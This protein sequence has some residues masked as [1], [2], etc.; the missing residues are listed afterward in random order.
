MEKLQKLVFRFV[1]WAVKLVYP[2]TTV[3]GLE[4]L[5][6][7]PAIIVANHAQMHGPIVG[8]LYFPGPRATWCAGEMMVLKEVP[9]YAYQDF[10]SNK[11]KYIRWFFKLASYVI[12]PLCV[13]VF[14]HAL[15]IPVWRGQKVIRTFRASVEGLKE[16][17]N[18]IIF[19]EHSQPHDHI[20]CDFQEG[21]VDLARMYYKQTG[22][23]VCFV[24]MYLA[25]ALHGAYLGEPVRYRAE[26]NI[27]DERRRICDQLMERISA[28]A[29]GLPEHRV[30]PYNNVPKKD[31][32]TNLPP[33]VANH[34]KTCC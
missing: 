4:H 14:N 19:P 6:E 27:K 23:E 24:P 33:E 1:R 29:C 8:E 10:W 3:H 7:E 32:G 28:L 16:G 12:A 5:P 21:F 26:E 15:T 30:V 18:I 25:P 22:K 13:C 20:L 2:R 34:E 11:P 31:Y 9:A 17:K